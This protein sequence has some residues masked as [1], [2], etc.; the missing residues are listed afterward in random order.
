MSNSLFVINHFHNTDV[1]LP[2]SCPGPFPTD[3]T[4]EITTFPTDMNLLFYNDNETMQ[5]SI[6][7]GIG[8]WST[9]WPITPWGGHFHAHIEG[10]QKWYFY[11]SKQYLYYF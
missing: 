1:L 5:N 8:N 11:S 6:L 7:N 2:R 9:K 3:E 10:T 4:I